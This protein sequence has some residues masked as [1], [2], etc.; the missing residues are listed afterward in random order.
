MPSDTSHFLSPFG[1]IIGI[2][3]PP[4]LGE[5]SFRFYVPLGFTFEVE[6]KYTYIFHVMN[7]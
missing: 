2:R 5:L 1:A 7:F 4:F 3:S 6:E